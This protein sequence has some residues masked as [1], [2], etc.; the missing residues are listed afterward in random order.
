MEATTSGNFFDDCLAPGDLEERF[1][2]ILS[3][4]SFTRDDILAESMAL[5]GRMQVTG[6]EAAQLAE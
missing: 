6:P 3:E 5:Q 2:Y 1:Y 4:V